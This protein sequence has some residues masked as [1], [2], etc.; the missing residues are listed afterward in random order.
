MVNTLISRWV[1][2]DCSFKRSALEHNCGC[3]TKMRL[4]I[5]YVCM[6]SF[7]KSK[8]GTCRVAQCF[9]FGFVL[10]MG[11]PASVMRYSNVR[12]WGRGIEGLVRATKRTLSIFYELPSAI[13]IQ[14][15]N[16]FHHL[17]LLWPNFWLERV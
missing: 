5:I 16:I 3:N 8:R 14:L 7:N 9:F 1:R 6:S 10:A 4:Q 15:Y 17:F 13:Y 2:V 12:G 11:I